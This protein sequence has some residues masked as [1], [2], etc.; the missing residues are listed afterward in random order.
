MKE[1]LLMAVC[2]CVGFEPNSNTRINFYTPFP[3]K[4]HFW[5]P[6]P[7]FYPLKNNHFQFLM[8]PQKCHDK[9]Q[10]EQIG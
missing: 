5:I 1:K 10:R 9:Y 4:K 8:R 3:K 7:F 2:C 6:F